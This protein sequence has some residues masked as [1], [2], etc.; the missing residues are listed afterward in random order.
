[1]HPLALAAKL[2]PILDPF[3]REARNAA[4]HAE[5]IHSYGKL[6]V[7]SL[8]DFFYFRVCLNFQKKCWQWSARRDCT[9]IV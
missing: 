2:E 6:R 8:L 9:L 3:G 5:A 4:L 1:M 7:T